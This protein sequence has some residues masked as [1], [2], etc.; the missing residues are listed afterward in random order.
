MDCDIQETEGSMPLDERSLV[1][2]KSREEIFAQA[3]EVAID[4]EISIIV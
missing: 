2:G 4:G 1:P 3:V